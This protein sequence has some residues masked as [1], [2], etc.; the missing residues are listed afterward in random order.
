MTEFNDLGLK[1][2]LIKKLKSNGI[3]KPTRVQERVIPLLLKGNDLIVQSET[4]SGKT[5]SF[6]TPLLQL[7]KNRVEALIITPTRELAKQVATELRKY[8]DENQIISVVYG[9]VA[10][11][12]KAKESNIIVGTPG[13]IND[14]INRGLLNLRSIKFF[15]LDEADRMLDM[16]FINDIK[17]IMKHTPRKKQ[18]LL[19][20]ATINTQVV[21][22]SKELMRNP[23][24]IELGTRVSSEKLKQ[25][26]Y[27]VNKK[28]KIRLLINLLK[29]EKGLSLVFCSTKKST[30]V[31]ANKL[32]K[33]GIKARALNGNMSQASREKVLSDYRNKRIRVLVATDV[34]ARGLDVNGIKLVINLDL[35]RDSKTYTHRIGR[36]ARQGREGKAIIILSEN[37]YPYMRRI[38]Q[39]HPGEIKKA[40]R[41]TGFEPA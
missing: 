24:I 38:Q 18:T 2:L 8:K 33:A 9:G 25:Y 20:S 23:V 28:E 12:E 35:P 41:G 40:V 11:Q 19:F 5:I 4:G 14:L 3:R 17:R 16:G 29:K 22:L 34:A 6:I 13:R 36:T 39:E 15:V 10:M 26:Y 32:I 31:I 21:R 30:E 27:D 1:P 37:D 7:V